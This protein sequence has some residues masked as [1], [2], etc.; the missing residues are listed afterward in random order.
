MFPIA[1]RDLDFRQRWYDFSWIHEEC[2]LCE[3]L[4]TIYGIFWFS[5]VVV[6]ILKVKSVGAIKQ[7]SS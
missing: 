4:A 6:M 1:L 7:S 5:I 3:I 2:E